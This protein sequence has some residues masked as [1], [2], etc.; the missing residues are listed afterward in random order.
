MPKRKPTLVLLILSICLTLAVPAFISGVGGFRQLGRLSWLVT[1]GLFGLTLLSWAFN[2]ARIRKL[3]TV[4]G[5]SLPLR[6]AFEIGIAAEFAGNATP[7][8]SGMSV[9]FAFLLK[10]FGV[11]LGPAMGMT[12]V[13]MILDVFFFISVILLS[14]IG[15][16]LHGSLFGQGYLVVVTIGIALMGPILL[17]LCFRYHRPLYHFL[18]RQLARYHWTARYRYR[19]ARAFVEA[20]RALK[21]FRAI[22]RW[23]QL[24]LALY[25]AGYWLPRY[26]ILLVAVDLVAGSVPIAYLFFIQG[27]L[28][29]GTDAFLIPAGGGGVD[30]LFYGLLTPFLPAGN[31]AFCL[32]VWRAFTFYIY[33]VIGGP[34]FL[35]RAG[36]RAMN[37]LRG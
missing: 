8:S 14:L 18:S 9:T 12:G 15:V 25:T 35:L 7:A 11:N 21:R 17:W 24:K 1:L 4:L 34:I 13:I 30:A 6:Q 2:G 36:K 16:V 22:S 29:L 3:V 10:D 20:I 32:I 27:F 5:K 19:L 37:L 23:D 26:C 31:I 33:L 28:F